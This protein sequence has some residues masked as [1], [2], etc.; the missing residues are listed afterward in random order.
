L[1][2]RVAVPTYRRLSLEIDSVASLSPP[3]SSDGGKKTELCRTIL[4]VSRI[5]LRPG[6]IVYGFRG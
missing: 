6:D 3:D 2:L 4:L 5:F 1:D